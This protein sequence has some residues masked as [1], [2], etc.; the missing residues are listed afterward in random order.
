MVLGGKVVTVRHRTGASTYHLLPGGGVGWGETLTDALVREVAEET[1]LEARVGRLLFVNDTVD[2]NGTRHIVNL[3]FE[4][5]ITGG[6]V[7]KKPQD[8]RVEAV[9]LFEPGDLASLDLRPP[10]ADALARALAGEALGGEYLGS[11][12]SAGR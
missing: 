11:L 12:F 2:P 7:T 6:T 8:R 3:T 1:G 4:A 5:E 9:D 10:L